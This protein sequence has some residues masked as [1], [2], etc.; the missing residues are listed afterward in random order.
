MI[1]QH[2]RDLRR[3]G[4]IAFLANYERHGHTQLEVAFARVILALEVENK[5]LRRALFELLGDPVG[6]PV[7]PEREQ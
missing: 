5:R 3:A 7:D 6:D 2:D 1:D 4:E